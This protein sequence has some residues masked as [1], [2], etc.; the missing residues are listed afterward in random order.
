[1]ANFWERIELIREDERGKSK[2][3]MIMGKDKKAN[4]PKISFFKNKIIIIYGPKY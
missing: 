1:L 3:Y 4:G 2:E